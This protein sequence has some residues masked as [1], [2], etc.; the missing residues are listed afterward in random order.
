MKKLLFLALL[1]LCFNAQAQDDSISGTITFSGTL[2]PKVFSL[3]I[4][5][6]ACDDGNDLAT[7]TT[8]LNS[9]T[10]AGHANDATL[11]LGDLTENSEDEDDVTSRFVFFEIKSKTVILKEDYL[12]IS[13][14]LT[15]SDN[16]IDVNLRLLTFVDGGNSVFGLETLG[17]PAAPATS[18]A[19]NEAMFSGDT[20]LTSTLSEVYNQST[21][22]PETVNSKV[23]LAASSNTN[24]VIRG[25]IEVAYGEEATS[26]DYEAVITTQFTAKDGNP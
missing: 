15:S 9:E 19:T 8:E 5:L 7:C 3:E 13:Q 22:N 14:A 23:L 1:G 17:D 21:D 10:F 18:L 20:A 12:V 25:I 26:E 4:A 16:D 6:K 24:L 11:A 2:S